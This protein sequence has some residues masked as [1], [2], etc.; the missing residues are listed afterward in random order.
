MPHLSQYLA[1]FALLSCSCAFAA[2]PPRLLID[3]A[4]EANVPKYVPTDCEVQVVQTGS[5]PALELA[6]GHRAP[7]PHLRFL[8]N[9]LGY[10]TDWSGFA[11]LAVTVSNPT[12]F[13][14]K[15]NVRVDSEGVK[16]R[17]RQGGIVVTPGQTVRV[18][19]EIGEGT[20]IVGMRGQPPVA[21]QRQENDVQIAHNNVALD[22]QRITRFQVFMGQPERDHT[23]LLHRIELIRADASSDR[24]AFVDRF[25]QYNGAEW[26]GKLRDESEFAER[27]RAEQAY[28]AANPPLPDR[29]S[30]G[31][32]KDGPQLEA[33]GRFRVQKHRGKWWLVDPTGRLFW[34]S[35]VTCVRFNAE[36]IVAGRRQYYEWLP[37]DGDPLARF[38]TGWPKRRMFDFFEAN[39]YRKY[40][41]DYVAEFYDVTV[42]RFQSWGINTIANW[43]DPE[44]WRMKR[45]PY[46][47]PIHVPHVPM[48]VATSHMKAGLEKKKW[49]PDPFDPEFREGLEKQLAAQSEF[50]DDPW[51]LGVFVHNELTWTLGAPWRSN[52]TPTGIGA[53]CLQKNDASLLAKR[54]LVEWLKQRHVA[55]ADLNRAWGTTFADWQA[56]AATFELTDAQRKQALTDLTELDKLVAQQYFRVCR[57]A[58][59]E[60]FPGV[61]YLGCRFSGMYDRHI[62]EI[63]R[64]NCDVVSFNIYDEL[65]SGRTADE[66]AAELDFPVVIGEFH[67]GSLDRGMFDPGLR[68][69]KD[70]AERAEKYAAY[71]R[72]AAIAPWC[73]G[74]HWFQYLDQALT[75][76]SDGE[77]YNIGFVD[78][79][80]DPYPE[81]R[82]AAR[83]VHGELY[84]IRYR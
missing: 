26:P 1:L 49:F 80:D 7:W 51:L 79:T 44:S 33:T 70:Q 14:V 60:H 43:S 24:T 71:I 58:M 62:V 67:F 20:A 55:V 78:A 76:R 9:R 82:D 39:A 84:R 45:M 21:Y 42:K 35:G 3:I 34:S 68:R 63:A 53:L 30:Y 4:E 57:E 83:K 64:E 16:D 25:G 40:G 8:S 75:G 47:I 52:R 66:L 38:Y 22:S 50:K 54:K 56:V 28:F 72:E 2:P 41:D 65:L 61:L 29:N 18:M 77:N 48:F 19:L 36:T 13:P 46:T 32:W 12:D 69:T 74:A 11:F 27:I 5:G 37:T 15:I 59:D 17:G 31:G 6:F 73:V 23:L 81:L 10:P